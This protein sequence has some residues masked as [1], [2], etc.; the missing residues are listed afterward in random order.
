MTKTTSN[1]H[2]HTKKRRISYVVIKNFSTMA[3]HDFSKF[4]HF[5]PS[6]LKSDAIE[7]KFEKPKHVDV[8]EMALCRQDYSLNIFSFQPE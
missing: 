1:D 6:K 5:Y 4:V 3:V 7:E 2:K 8:G